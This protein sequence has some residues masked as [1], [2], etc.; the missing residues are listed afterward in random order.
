MAHILKKEKL[1]N[2]SAVMSI[3]VVLIHSMNIWNYNLSLQGTTLEKIVFCIE[4]FISDDIARIGVPSFFMLSGLLFYR[5]FDFS[6]YPSKMKSRFFSLFIPYLLWN[7]F[8]FAYLYALGKFS[9]EGSFLHE[10]RVVFTIPNLL[11]GLFFYKYNLGYWFMY[12]LILY[13][14]LCPLVYVLLKKKPVGI[15]TLC[16]LV[17]LFC[18][19]ILGDFTINVCNRRF[20]QIDG[21]FYY[22]LGA[23][24]GLHHFELANKNSKLT[25]RLGLCGV[26]LGQLLY[27]LFH[28]THWL[29]FHIAFCAVSAISFWYLFDIF[30]KKNL[31]AAITTI[32]FFIYSAHGT[33]LELLQGFVAT[34]FPIHA[35]T[36]LIEYLLL[37]VITLAILVVIS[38]ALKRFTPR[39]WKLVNGGR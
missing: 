10:T 28:V 11:E 34:Y 33:V 20:L 16:A 32:T 39:V 27:V 18:S 24:V 15:I 38:C 19:D 4:K 36:A 29:F 1:L 9:P 22:M 2:Y 21:L 17:V 3:L 23:F 5:D 14:L 25:R 6:K 35:L 31:P 12:Q 7:L 37:P 26:L 13:T 30:G 8:R